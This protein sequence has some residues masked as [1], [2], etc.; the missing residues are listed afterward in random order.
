[1]NGMKFTQERLILIS[2]AFPACLSNLDS[3]WQLAGLRPA[4]RTIKLFGKSMT[5][6][7]WHQSKLEGEG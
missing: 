4:A 6:Y 5:G 7:H 1:M 2:S 3:E